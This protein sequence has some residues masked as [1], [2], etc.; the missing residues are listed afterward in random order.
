VGVGGAVSAAVL[1]EGGGFLFH[2]DNFKVRCLK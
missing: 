1:Q 2:A